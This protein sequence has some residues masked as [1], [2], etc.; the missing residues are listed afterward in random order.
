MVHHS[1]LT[2]CENNNVISF[3]FLQFFFVRFFIVCLLFTHST[4]LRVKRFLYFSSSYWRCLYL[5]S[6]YCTFNQFRCWFFPFT[7]QQNSIVIGMSTKKF[8]VFCSSVFTKNY[9]HK[10]SENDTENSGVR[11]TCQNRIF[12]LFLLSNDRKYSYRHTYQIKTCCRVWNDAI[13]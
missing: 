11:F 3:F 12:A 10:L 6:V 2:L 4:Q 13:H 7:F 5:R 1:T 9:N 8:P